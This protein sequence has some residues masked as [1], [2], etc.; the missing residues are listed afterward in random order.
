MLGYSREP[1]EGRHT[2]SV[3]E[4]VDEVMLM[5]SKEFLGGLTLT[6]ELNPDTP[7]VKG[8]RGRLEQ[9]VLNLVVNAAEAM[10]G[11]GRL[12][13]AVREAA[14][15]N[16]DFVLRPRPAE[17]FVELLVADTGPGIDPSI[18]GRIFE[19][20]FSTKPQS[21]ASGTGLGLSLVHSL[22]EQEGM[23]IRLQSAPGE[24]TVFS[25]LVPAETTRKSE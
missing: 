7:L 16:G 8:A 1:A 14:D 11:K 22:A 25:I 21:A 6:L 23:G 10:D 18:R 2:F 13:I 19:P 3:P 20:F 15:G 4:V 9:I 17:R 24:G 5:L 12:L